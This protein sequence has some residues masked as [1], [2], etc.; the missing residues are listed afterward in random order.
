MLLNDP[1]GKRIINAFMRENVP[2][3]VIGSAVVH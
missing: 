1:H 3:L 2:S